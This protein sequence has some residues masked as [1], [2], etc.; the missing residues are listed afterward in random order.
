MAGTYKR[1]YPHHPPISCALRPQPHYILWLHGSVCRC[2][3]VCILDPYSFKSISGSLRLYNVGKG[4]GYGSQS[5]RA[6][7]GLES[8]GTGSGDA[9]GVPETVHLL[10]PDAP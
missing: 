4:M 2:A 6:V 9:T 1:M 5:V 8:S 3:K 7:K 10:V